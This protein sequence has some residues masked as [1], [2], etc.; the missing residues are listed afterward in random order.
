MAIV[1]ITAWI[2]AKKSNILRDDVD[3][4]S[5]QFINAVKQ[6]RRY[7]KVTDL[8]KIPHPYS[9]SRTQICVWTIIIAS[10][11]LYLY[12][13]VGGKVA[14]ALTINQTALWLMGISAATAAI[15]G[16]IDSTQSTL[17]RHQNEPSSGFW[18]DLLSDDNGISIH[19]FQNVLWTII[20]MGIYVYKVYI[21]QDLP[22]LDPTLI[23][24]TG[25]SSATYVGM[26]IQENNASS[27]G[28]PTPEKAAT[29]PP[30]QAPTGAINP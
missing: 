2:L 1:I 3:I 24:L 15:G 7:S 19:R 20:A 17:Q 5:Q 21:T 18:T 26:K 4:T 30:N 6:S 29:Q 12:F 25:I 27:Q 11:Y 10:A 13:C 14:A 22:D 8:S 9:L 16:S 23:G 28:T